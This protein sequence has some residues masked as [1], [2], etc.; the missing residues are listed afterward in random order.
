MGINVAGRVVRRAVA[1]LAAVAI[2][3]P[4]VAGSSAPVGAQAPPLVVEPSTGLTDG[5]EVTVTVNGP[6][7]HVAQCHGRAAANPTLENLR[8]LC[9][10]S[11]FVQGTARPGPG[12]PH[13]AVDSDVLHGA[14]RRLRPSA[15]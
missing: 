12:H 6:E 11:T 1:V 2:G 4:L 5:Q 3:W 15:R 8:D 14:D 13:G 9:G 10:N 7:T